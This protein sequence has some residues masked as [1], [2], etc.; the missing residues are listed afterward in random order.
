MSCLY[1]QNEVNGLNYKNPSIGL[2]RVEREPSKVGVS[3]CK[4]ILAK[5]AGK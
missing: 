2:E 5:V 4:P 1:L 3:G